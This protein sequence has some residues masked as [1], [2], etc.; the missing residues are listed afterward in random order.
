MVSGK[1]NQKNDPKNGVITG[2]QKR[3]INKERDRDREITRKRENAIN[4]ALETRIGKRS[5]IL[6][7]LL[8]LYLESVAK[9]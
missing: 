7:S 1:K 4:E 5:I 6:P 2:E 3:R 9:M 8:T